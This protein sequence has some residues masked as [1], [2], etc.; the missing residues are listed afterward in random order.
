[1][2]TELGELRVAVAEQTILAQDLKARLAVE[3]ARREAAVAKED[4]S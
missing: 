4:K 1:M 3:T 2:S